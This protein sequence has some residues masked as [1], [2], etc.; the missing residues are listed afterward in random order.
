MSN[1][2][3]SNDSHTTAVTDESHTATAD[4]SHISTDDSNMATVSALLEPDKPNLVKTSVSKTEVSKAVPDEVMLREIEQ[5]E[6]DNLH[7][8]YNCKHKS[9]KV[10]SEEE[11]ARQKLLKK[12]RM[13]HSWLEEKDLSYCKTTG[14][15][16]LIFSENQGIFCFLCRKHKTLN[17]QNSAAVFS[18]SPGTRYLKEALQEHE[19]TKMHKAAVEAEMNQRVS[20]FHSQY[21]EKHAVHN[22][23]LLNAFTVL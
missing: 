23:V 15:W 17:T 13:H 2:A 12:R 11:E 18:S 22:D 6:L 1:A 14:I 8:F 21:E 10:F 7:N 9:C 19:A 5:L 20:L 4:D 3:T 16:W